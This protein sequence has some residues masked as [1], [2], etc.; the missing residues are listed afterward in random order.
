MTL[1]KRTDD[2]CATLLDT[3]ATFPIRHYSTDNLQSSSTLIPSDQHR[4]GKEHIW[5]IA[6][7]TL[8]VRP[9]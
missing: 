3:L 9:I 8:H 4:I 7:M 1:G 2:A 5:K 6:R